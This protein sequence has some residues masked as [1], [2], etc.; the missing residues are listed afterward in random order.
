[1]LCVVRQRSLLPSDHSSRGDLANVVCLECGREVSMKKR[2]LSTR[3]CCLMGRG[4]GP[5]DV[6]PSVVKL[7]VFRSFSRTETQHILVD[8]KK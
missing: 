7:D 4:G 2:P 6:Q 3:R 1:M 8:L 5:L